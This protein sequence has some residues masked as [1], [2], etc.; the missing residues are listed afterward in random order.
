LNLTKELFYMPEVASQHGAAIDSMIDYVHWLMLA[1]F[2][3]WGAFFVFTIFRFRAG[4][5]KRADYKGVKSH[6]STYLEIG[7]AVAEAILLIGFSIP[8]WAERMDDVPPPGESVVARVIAEQFVWN[9]HYPGKDGV[10]GRTSVD[11]INLETNP[12]GLDRDDPAAADDITTVNQLHLPVDK[13]AVLHLSSKDVIHSFSLPHMRIK[14]D[15]IPGLSI[16]MW[17]VPTVTTE[18]MREKL[19]NPE[20]QYEIACAQ[21]CGLGH[22]R[23]RGFLT[24]HDQAGYDAWIDE[25]TELLAESGADDFWD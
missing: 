14:Q 23:M 2:I 11:L 1:L 18:Q 12:V 8:L 22:Y 19:G 9:V 20:F 7:V 10:F 21:L 17:F 5:N 25:E 16:P 4:R 6:T 15:T 3:G 24:V 13:P